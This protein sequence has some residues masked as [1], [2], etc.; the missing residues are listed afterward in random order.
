LR[1]NHQSDQQ[2]TKWSGL[3]TRQLMRSPAMCGFLRPSKALD[4]M[5]P[6]QGHV[7]RKRIECPSFN[8]ERSRTCLATKSGHMGARTNQRGN[9]KATGG[10]NWRKMGVVAM[11]KIQSRL[12]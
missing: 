5:E 12:W 6:A 1:L 10:C 4:K 2:Q 11:K 8:R 9:K 7:S 3:K